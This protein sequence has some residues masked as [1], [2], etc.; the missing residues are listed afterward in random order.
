MGLFYHS[1]T[2]EE[3]QRQEDQRAANAERKKQL[4]QIKEEQNEKR[5]NG[6]PE[7]S[8]SEVRDIYRA[9]QQEARRA[10]ENARPQVNPRAYSVKRS[11]AK[12]V[13]APNNTTVTHQPSS[14]K[15]GKGSNTLKVWMLRRG[16]PVEQDI[17]VP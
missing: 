5:G 1:M 2:E 8:H 14:N 16:E 4:E 13:P 17:M 3:R 6:A 11:D 15:S 12:P 9:Q 7:I 10:L